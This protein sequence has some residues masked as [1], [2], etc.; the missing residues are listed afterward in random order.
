MRIAT[1]NGAKYTGTLDRL[2]SVERGKSADLLLIDGDPTADISKIR[3]I[4][5]VMKEGVA[6]FPA[7][8]YEALGVQR[9]VDPPPIQ[10]SGT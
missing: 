1:W 9:F 2:G 7:E 10:S 4:R 6:Y 8:V 3:R 5:L